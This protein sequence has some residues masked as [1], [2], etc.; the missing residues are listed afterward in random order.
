MPQ[1]LFLNCQPLLVTDNLISLSVFIV[2]LETN[3][4]F[5]SYPRVKD[6]DADLKVG[7]IIIKF[8]AT[9]SQ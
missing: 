9:F 7:L 6:L 4:K 1:L 2:Y 3:M 8:K 5:Q